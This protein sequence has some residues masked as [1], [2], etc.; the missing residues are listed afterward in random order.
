MSGHAVALVGCKAAVQKALQPFGGRAL[1]PVHSFTRDAG[2]SKDN[3]AKCD[4]P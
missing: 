1:G 2:S 4:Q 3:T